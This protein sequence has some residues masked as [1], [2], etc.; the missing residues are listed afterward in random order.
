MKAALALADG[1][2]FYGRAFGATGEGYVNLGFFDENGIIEEDCD[3]AA[4]YL[5]DGSPIAG[6]DAL[7][8]MPGAN[9]STGSCIRA[10]R[11][12][13]RIRFR[14]LV[15]LC[16]KRITRVPFAPQVGQWVKAA[17]RA[18]AQWIRRVAMDAGL[19]RSGLAGGT[20]R[21]EFLG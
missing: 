8:L 5:Y 9:A 1:R 20:P 18:R 3:S 13:R 4:V 14:I 6:V 12:R 19:C 15:L 16:H 17:T 11:T 21:D 7:P 2:V 10:S